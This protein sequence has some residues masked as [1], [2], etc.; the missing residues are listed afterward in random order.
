MKVRIDT[1][2]CAGFGICVG[3]CPEMFELRIPVSSDDMNEMFSQGIR[4]PKDLHE[5]SSGLIPQDLSD[6]LMD[7]AGCHDLIVLFQLLKRLFVLFLFFLLWPNKEKI[8]YNEYCSKGEN[9]KILIY[10]KGDIKKCGIK[11]KLTSLEGI[12]TKEEV[13]AEVPSIVEDIKQT[14]MLAQI[15]V[16]VDG[17]N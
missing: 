8:E 11:N 12:I 13:E 9:Y 17:K 16:S 4:R 3:I 15:K 5:L 7:A 10:P 14:L 2:L 1:E 6:A